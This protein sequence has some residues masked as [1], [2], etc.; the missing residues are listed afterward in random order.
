MVVCFLF[1]FF[2]ACVFPAR[3][4]KENVVSKPPSSALEGRRDQKD[5]IGHDGDY[6]IKT[7]HAKPQRLPR[8]EPVPLCPRR[9]LSSLLCEDHSKCFLKTKMSPVEPEVT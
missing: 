7:A 1:F 2:N 4:L 3:G 8:N 6:I 9:C 5:L